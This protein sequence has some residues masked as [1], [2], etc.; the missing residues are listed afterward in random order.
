MNKSIHSLSDREYDD[1]QEKEA[2]FARNSKVYGDFDALLA[3]AKPSKPSLWKRF[4]IWL[5]ET[6][7]M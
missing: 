7:G 6:F 1:L 2:K 5:R 3:T 4:K